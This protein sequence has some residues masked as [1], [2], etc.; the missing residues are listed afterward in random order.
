[1]NI[2]V[3]CGG[4][5]PERDVSLASGANICSAL[6]TSGHRAKRL[7]LFFGVKQKYKNFDEF[8]EDDPPTFKHSEKIKDSA[9]NT[10]ELYK[11]RGTDYSSIGENVIELCS[12][13]DIVFIA[14]HGNE[15][16]D[17]K[18]QALF[19]LYR[20]KYTGSD[21]FSC[22]MAMEKH[23]SK[24]I[25]TNEKI[26]VPLGISLKKSDSF[27][28]KIPMPCVVK[29]CSC[30]SSIGVSI[31]HS[32]SELKDALHIA[33]KYSE[34]VIIEE[35]IKGR[36]FAVGILNGVAL[37]PIEII[38]KDGFFDYKNKYSAE[39]T[40]EVCPAN[41]DD[42]LQKRMMDI[43][44][45]ANDALCLTVYS[46]VDF[47]VSNNLEIVCL[48]VNALPGMTEASLLPKEAR[49][50]RIQYTE[51]CNKIVNLSLERFQS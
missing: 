47:I 6:I 32:E 43:A 38:P 26:R 10:D 2:I 40:L 41:I 13:A 45:R 20:I 37:P 49:A 7:D 15:G 22:S 29:P 18:L 23:V 42:D 9:P 44:L 28:N 11:R 25:L 46:R 8:Y 27:N 1:M 31:V 33:F 12:M 35:Y 14:L 3:L 4:I 50:A 51:L 48:E 36:E 39:K 17:G 30:G 19:D 34:R 5:S 21:Y 16:E 24:N